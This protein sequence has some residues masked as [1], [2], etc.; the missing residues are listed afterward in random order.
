LRSKNVK[1]FEWLQFSFFLYTD[2]DWK[3][4]L[5]LITWRDYEIL[6]SSPRKAV[7]EDISRFFFFPQH[8]TIIHFSINVCPAFLFLC[9]HQLATTNLDIILKLFHKTFKWSAPFVTMVFGFVL[10]YTIGCLLSRL[11]CLK[12]CQIQ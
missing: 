1:T 5:M 3:I 11:C 8:N 12:Q 9:S 6:H 10:L 7:Q 2:H 4:M